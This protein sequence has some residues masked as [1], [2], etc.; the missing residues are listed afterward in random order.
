MYLIIRPDTIYCGLTID[1]VVAHLVHPR[2]LLL[3]DAR[4][5]RRWLRGP[6]KLGEFASAETGEEG[7]DV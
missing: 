3:D 4:L 1:G 7:G 5:A 2:Q 6:R